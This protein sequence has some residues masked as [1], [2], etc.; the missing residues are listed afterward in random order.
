MKKMTKTAR[1]YA[2]DILSE[3]LIDDAYSNISINKAF[4]RNNIEIVDKKYITE[5]VYGSIKNKIYLEHII[6]LFSKGRIKPKV[7]VLLITSLYQILKMDKTPNFAA[8]NETVE[9]AKKLFGIHTS[10]FVN[11]LL[12]NV[13]RNYNQNNISYNNDD[14]KFCIENSCPKELYDILIK[15]YGKE[16]ARLIVAS[17]NK[18]SLNSIRVNTNKITKEE[19]LSYFVSKNIRAEESEITCDTLVLSSLDIKDKKFQE[20]SYIIQDEASALVAHTISE[21]TTKK[22]KILDVCAAPGGKSLHI[23]SL[24]KN[25]HVTSCDK[26]EHK[27]KL[28]EENAKKLSVSNIDIKKQDATELN[29]QFLEKFD[30]VV[31]DVP[32]SGLGVIKNKPEIKY[33]ITNKHIEEIVTLQKQILNNSVKYLKEGGVLIYSTCTIDKRENEYNIQEFL[34]KNSN[35][36]L[37]K[38]T[39]DSTIK[40]YKEGML[41]IL[42]DEYN[43]DGFFISKLRKIV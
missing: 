28:I 34:E 9:L 17:F 11:A 22:W 23:A 30:I 35:F 20:G 33:K 27:L 1:E 43:C 4:S 42:P 19:L 5:I 29:D 41:N 8:V 7:K 18:N 13:I 32:C 3:I 25:S 39:I 38:I 10:K 26:Y 21:D 12:R 37:E 36:R 40:E 31:C 6:K 24:Y 2:Y 15:Q 16:K 14:E